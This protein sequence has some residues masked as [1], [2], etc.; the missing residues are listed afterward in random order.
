MWKNCVY[1]KELQKK[2]CKNYC[3]DDLVGPCCAYFPPS[4]GCSEQAA[5]DFQSHSFIFLLQLFTFTG[6]PRT[7][8]YTNALP[9]LSIHSSLRL[10]FNRPAQHSFHLPLNAFA[11][12]YRSSNDSSIQCSVFRASFC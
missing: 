1:T 6:P 3:Q 5:A 9:K 8:F 12:F 2:T 11:T 10:T 7:S 4:C